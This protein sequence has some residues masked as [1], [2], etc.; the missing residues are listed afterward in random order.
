MALKAVVFDF[1]GTLMDTETGAYEAISSIYAEHGQELALDTWAVCIGTQGAFDPY[2]EL[3]RR[4]GKTL[5]RD[6]LHQLFRTRH[7]E[8][9]KNAP[10]RPGVV[11]RL[12]EARRLGWRIGLASSSDLA[13]IEGHLRDQGIR[14]YF[15]VIRSSDDV[16]RVKP[17][18]E[19]Y[20]LAVEALGV[21][22]GEAVAIEDSMNGLRAAKAA[23]LWGLAVP[24]GVTKQMDFSE[25]DLIVDGLDRTTF[26]QVQATI[27]SL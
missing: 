12:E 6:E 17:D 18:P 16:K 22:P 1:D 8:Y 15:E 24:N 7:V 14:D 20:L 25:A 2:E 5:D 23:G 13:W 11:E 21:K 10:L 27:A 3:Q 26:E 9:L 19:L 4:T